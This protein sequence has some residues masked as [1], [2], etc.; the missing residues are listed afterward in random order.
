MSK[1]LSPGYNVAPAERFHDIAVPVNAPRN[2]T[3]RVLLLA[4]DLHIANAVE[5]HVSSIRRL[6]RHQIDVVNP[7]RSPAPPPEG[8]DK[9]DALLIHYSIL[10][11]GE[12]YLPPEFAEFVKNFPG[13]KA[14][15]IQDEC[16][17]VNRMKRRMAELGIGA[18]FSSLTVDNMRRVYGGAEL[19]AVSFF[20][21]L[22][23]YISDR[24][25]TIPTLPIK[26]RPL[27]IVYR[28]RDLPYWLGRH[29]QEKSLIAPQVAAIARD[30][31][32]SVDIESS[33]NKR[34]YGYDWQRFLMSGR[35]TVGVEGGASI[36]DFDGAAEAAVKEYLQS[37]PGASFEEV[38]AAVLQNYEGNV[39]HQTITP[40]IFEAI[41]TRTA[42]VLYPGHYRGILEEGRHYLTL[43][44]DGSN[45]GELVRL[46]RD[47]QAL[48]AFVDRTYE[49]IV[50]RSDLSM[51]YYVSG[52]DHVLSHLHA[53]SLGRLAARVAPR[54]SGAVDLGGAGLSR[55][56]IEDRLA[57]LELGIRR[58][59]AALEEGAQDSI[60]TLKLEERF[61]ELEERLVRR[62]TDF[63]RRRAAQ[64]RK[65]AERLDRLDKSMR[66]RLEKLERRLGKAPRP[67]RVR[68]ADLLRRALPERM[69]TAVLH[70]GRQIR[71]KLPGRSKKATP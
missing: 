58:C 33:E 16:R 36:F 17:W 38:S 26:D 44:R 50:P 54:Q 3:L 6:S 27:D 68:F 35:A 40:K 23:G 69:A 53:S 67:L 19:E 49:E 42:L 55:E 41:A 57:D 39:V 13:A 71:A 56:E 46:L 12:T 66:R 52:I 11:L 43:Q 45:A 60:T 70:A 14:Q 2:R 5:D 8:R 20:S 9:Y 7:M 29:A 18:V 25:K 65:A 10:I 63:E 37:K 34:I 62:L 59:R 28:G 47:D 22:P 31:G 21:C 51:S 1:P 15:I 30:Y 4:D 61:A 48:Q 24:L 32:L 64:D